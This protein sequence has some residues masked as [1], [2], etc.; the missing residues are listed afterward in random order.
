MA[1]KIEFDYPD[2]HLLCA[3]DRVMCK[4]SMHITNCERVGGPPNSSC[5]QH[6]MLQC[7]FNPVSEK[8]QTAEFVFDVMNFMQQLQ[9][10]H[11]PFFP[12]FCCMRCPMVAAKWLLSHSLSF[13]SP[14]FVC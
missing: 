2:A 13:D 12:P 5:T 3:G 1:C 4:Y 11:S 7:T 10:F 8:I 14:A 6:G 9:V